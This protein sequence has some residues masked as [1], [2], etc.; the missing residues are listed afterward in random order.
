MTR[1]Q[2][3]IEQLMQKSIYS[4]KN[5][6]LRLAAKELE[7]S[8]ED[9]AAACVFEKNKRSEA[10]QA[11][12]LEWQATPEYKV[13]ASARAAVEAK[14]QEA[15]RNFEATRRGAQ[16]ELRKLGYRREKTT[17]S[18]SSYYWNVTKLGVRVTIRVTDHGVPM[19]D[20]R[21]AAS[22]AG[23]HTWADGEDTIMLGEYTPSTVRDAVRSLVESIEDQ[24]IVMVL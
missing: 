5:K 19:T 17:E 22:N 14:E 9:L 11:Q 13:K 24:P 1:K 23:Y 15:V 2:K 7:I 12:E 20:A 3:I 6:T 16:S 10:C 21:E 18:G 8:N 4:P